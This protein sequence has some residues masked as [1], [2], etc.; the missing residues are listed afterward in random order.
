MIAT[1]LCLI[2]IPLGMYV[3]LKDYEKRHVDYQDS[4][5]LYQDNSKGKIY[6][7]FRA[8][9]YH[10][11]SPLSIFSLGLKYTLPEKVLTSH[12]GQFTIERQPSSQSPQSV[13]FGEVDFNFIM[14]FVLSILALIFTFNRIS[15]EKEAGSLRLVISNSVPRWKII[16]AKILGNYV[17]FL[18][19]FFIGLLV[20]LVILVTSGDYPLFSKEIFPSFMAIS[21]IS[22][23]FIFVIFNLGILNSSKS[24]SSI[25]SMISAL[26]AWVIIVLIVPKICP[27]IAN[28]IYPVKAQ[29]IV[30]V[31][32]QMA[33]RDLEKELDS[34]RK[35][36]LERIMTNRGIDPQTIGIFG[37]KANSEEM[38]AMHQYDKDIIPIENEYKERINNAI[39]KIEQDHNNKRNVQTAIAIN[40]SRISPTCSYTYLLSEISGTGFKEIENFN[41]HAQK[42][43]TTGRK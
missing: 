37:I 43:S 19:P 16:L 28:I 36:L 7:Q 41:K 11:P 20:A 8:Q 22:L 10:P 34:K 2:L 29:Q 40:L 3:S 42:F 32:K 31:E 21:L 5:H 33:K 12:D 6:A 30:T 15:G 4:I 35:E 27:M 39:K 26:F 25:T 13:L 23:V 14:S 1:L 18:V 9:G 38:K 24:H 17:I